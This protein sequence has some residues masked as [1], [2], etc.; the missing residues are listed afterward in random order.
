MFRLVRPFK[1]Y[2]CH[3]EGQVWSAFSAKYVSSSKYD[4]SRT[5][6]AAN[7]TDEPRATEDKTLFPGFPAYNLWTRV[8][9]QPLKVY[10]VQ[11]GC[12]MGTLQEQYSI[13]SGN[14]S[15]QLEHFVGQD[16]SSPIANWK[17]W[18]HTLTS[19]LLVVFSR[20][21][22]PV[23]SPL[24]TAWIQSSSTLHIFFFLKQ[25]NK[26]KSPTANCPFAKQRQY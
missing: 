10:M 18:W 20:A 26:Q 23:I 1:H 21:K 14:P 8:D 9:G 16:E 5:L 7:K 25:R 11:V 15:F 19:F 6:P 22:S 4:H 13:V 17:K 3:G 12:C 2:K 24:Q